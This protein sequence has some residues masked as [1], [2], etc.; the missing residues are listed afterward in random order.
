MIL[1]FNPNNE[2][3]DEDLERCP[4]FY[5]DPQCAKWHEEDDKRLYLLA[6]ERYAW[7]LINKYRGPTR[8]GIPFSIITA[9]EMENILPKLETIFERDDTFYERIKK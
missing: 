3:Y 1:E 6:L 7:R 2:L 9:T 8:S 4:Y 5:K